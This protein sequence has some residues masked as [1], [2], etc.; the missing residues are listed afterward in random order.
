MIRRGQQVQ[1]CKLERSR[2]DGKNTSSQST[3]IRSEDVLNDGGWLFKV[4]FSDSSTIRRY[5]WISDDSRELRWGVSRQDPRYLRVIL[6]DVVGMTFGPLT[7]AFSKVFD[8]GE[9]PPPWC[10]FSLIFVGRTL[11]LYSPVDNADSWFLHIQRITGSVCE[12]ALPALSRSDVL[13]RKV[14]M[15]IVAKAGRLGRSLGEHF[16]ITLSDCF[17]QRQMS[18]IKPVK[19]IRIKSELSSLRSQL[20]EFRE[21]VVFVREQHWDVLRTSFAQLVDTMTRTPI[22]PDDTTLLNELETERSERKR[23]HNELMDLRG[24]IRVFTRVRP[25]L[26]TDTDHSEDASV[27]VL[28]SDRLSVYNGNDART[29]NFEFD[30]VFSPLS[31]QEDIFTQVE[32]FITSFLDGFNVCLFAYGVTNS[33][34]TFTMEGTPSMP[35]MTYRSISKIFTSLPSTCS[36]SLSAVQI[37]NESLSDLLAPSSSVLE[38]RGDA[39][40]IQGLTSLA[41]RSAEEAIALIQHAAVKRCTNSTKLNEISSRS[42][43]VVTLTLHAG[44]RVISKLNLIDLAGSEN[45]NRSGAAG[46]VLKEAQSINKSLSALGDVVH[47]LLEKAAHVPF[48][49][50][51]LTM[52]LKDSLQGSSKVLMIVQVSP[53]QSDIGETLNSLQFGA[54]VRTVE[55]GKAKRNPVPSLRE[56][57]SPPRE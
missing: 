27:T 52:L 32:S 50:S 5:F 7:T 49:N 19:S 38:M 22:A 23:L 11:D 26:K 47:A 3:R 20:E 44:K 53:C 41:V 56:I 37:Y 13:R 48:R 21:S 29:R 35:G 15:K 39:F 4:G 33:G 17:H 6:R 31:T 12:Q 30:Q 42:H 10:C 28:G 51:K 25:L 18:V 55:L 54:R 24:N 16:R 1:A 45:V 57:S 2:D 46:K 34:K 8:S 43:F 40:A 36:I 14:F 9:H